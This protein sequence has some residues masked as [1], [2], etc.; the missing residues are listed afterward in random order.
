MI[1]RQSDEGTGGREEER[2]RREGGSER[3]IHLMNFLRLGMLQIAT[4]VRFLMGCSQ[5]PG[6]PS[7]SPTCESRT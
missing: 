2:E 6:T 7:W 3:L 5:E 1:E 4:I